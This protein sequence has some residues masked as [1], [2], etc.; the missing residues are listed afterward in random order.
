MRS[1]EQSPA[2]EGHLA[3]YRKLVPAIAL[4]DH[5]ADNHEG[6]VARPSILHALAFAAY[7]ESHAR[8]VYG[9][10]S[11]VEL[12]AAKAILK[13]IHAG[14]LQDKFTLR[15]VHQRDWAHLGERE[16]VAAGLGLLVDLNYLAE[17]A[18]AVGA[19]G[20]RPKITYAINPRIR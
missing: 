18:P 14:D 9:S 15:D 16:H 11:E 4:I 2:L 7:L 8:R 10:A 1:G 6:A 20:G 13:H 17:M 5:I 3:K 19:L 12:A